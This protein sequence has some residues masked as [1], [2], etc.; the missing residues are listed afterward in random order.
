VGSAVSLTP[1]ARLIVAAFTISG[2]L[3]LVRPALFDPLIPPVLPHP[4]AWTVASGVV[5]IGCAIGL[6]RGAAWAPR[7]TAATLVAVWPGNWWYAIATQRSGAHP[8]HK[9]AAWLRLPLQVPLTQA[10]LNPWRE[11]PLPHAR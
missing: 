11:P 3:H 7:A 6:A 4:R 8:T 9:A 1:A 2:G 5:E 10:A